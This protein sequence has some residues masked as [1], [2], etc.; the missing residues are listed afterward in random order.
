V[1]SLYSN[2]R[3]V[4]PL[5]LQ[6]QIVGTLIKRFLISIYVCVVVSLHDDIASY[7]KDPI[8]EYL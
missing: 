7:F 6:K 2:K 5:L 1:H 8:L 3:D 4:Q